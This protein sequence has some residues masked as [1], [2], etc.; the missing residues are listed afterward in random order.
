[1]ASKSGKGS[2]SIP[3]PVVVSIAHVVLDLATHASCPTCGNQVVLYL[4]F[5]CKK[6]VVPERGGAAA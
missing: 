4:C 1:M 5:N 6:I 3:L 2:T